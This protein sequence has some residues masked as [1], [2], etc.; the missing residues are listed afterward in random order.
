M[1]RVQPEAEP[2]ALTM[3]SLLEAG[4]HFGHP[5]RRWNPRMKSYIFTQRNGIHIIDLQQTLRLVERACEFVTD[6]VAG[7]GILLFVGTKKQAQESV[8]AEASRAGMPYVNQRW[9]GGTLTNWQTIKSRIDHMKDLEKQEE[10]GR[11]AVLSKKEALK[12]GERMARLQKYFNGVRDLDRIPDAIFIIDLVKEKIAVA[13][14]RRVGVPIIGL[15]DTDADPD[16]VDHVIPGNDDAIRSIRLMCTHI[17]DACIKG[18]Q[19]Y[20]QAQ[21]EA[22]AEAEEEAEEEETGEFYAEEPDT[23]E[24]APDED[25]ASPSTDED[26]EDVRAGT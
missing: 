18:S 2:Q 3:K 14:A 1:E 12:I 7:G 23:P 9:L 4:T 6:L 11:L 19:S 25:I 10:E 26:D 21:A 16:V 8:A 17:A 5:T 13:E 20:E 15:M 22:R 24:P